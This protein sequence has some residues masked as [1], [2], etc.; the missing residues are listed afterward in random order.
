MKTNTLFGFVLAL[1]LLISS[2]PLVAAGNVSIYAYWVGANSQTL[3]VT[4]GDIPQ[5][6]ITGDSL[7]PAMNI[8]VE[9]LKNGQYVNTILKIDNLTQDSYTKQISLNTA[10]LLGV[11][12]VKVTITSYNAQDTEVLTLTVNPKVQTPPPPQPQN[13][14]PILNP[15]GNKFVEAG[16]TLEFT[17]TASD[18]DNDPLLFSAAP[19]PAGTTFN[20]V[21]GKYKYLP[22]ITGEHIIKFVVSDGKAED[23]ESIKITVT[24]AEEKPAPVP[25]PPVPPQN[26]PPVM[27]PIPTLHVNEGDT[28]SYKVSGTDAEHNQLTFY[29][30]TVIDG[31]PIDNN[32]FPV[33]VPTGAKF[34]AHT[35]VFTFSPKFDF[36]K[37]PKK[38]ETIQLRFKAY[39]GKA[40]STWKFVN[41]IV[42]DV[43]RKPV[44]VSSTD[45]IIVYAGETVSL[46]LFATDADT[47]DVLSYTMKNAPAAATLINTNFSWKTN[48]HD[49]GSYTMTFMVSDGLASDKYDTQLIVK[50]KPAVPKSQCSDGKDNDGDH[51]IDMNDP[52]CS[53]P[54]DNDEINQAPPPQ[55]NTPPVI[56]SIHTISGKEGQLIQF[57]FV[58]FD[59]DGDKLTVTPYS[60]DS[61]LG[62][63]APIKGEG[64]HVINN[65]DGTFTVQLK[66][67]Y[68]FVKHPQTNRTFTLLL[69][70]NDGKT[71]TSRLVTVIVADVNQ[72]PQFQP[73]SDRT[74]YVGDNLTFT[75]TADDA[76]SEDTLNYAVQNLPVGAKFNKSGFKWQP[77][78]SQVGTH[79]V[80]FT[81]SDGFV[82]VSE[83]VLITVLAKNDG[84]NNP[85]PTPP[86]AKTQCSDGLDN[87]GDGLIDMKDPG[88]SSALDNDEKNTASVP[89]PVVPPAK[90]ESVDFNIISVKIAPEVVILSQENSTEVLITVRNESSVKAEDLRAVVMIPDV[91]L[92]QSTRR[93]VLNAEKDKTVGVVLDIPYETPAGTYLVQIMLENE[94]FH[95]TMYRQLTIIK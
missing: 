49:L 70:L 90:V 87:D 27:N 95:N 40:F 52:G 74:V 57:S 4:Q 82:T 5:I 14:A 80:T 93:F 66:P 15:I 33:V 63:L 26:T 30:H 38:Q 35:G 8:S 58:V 36:V 83:P 43:N 60:A 7:A 28:I 39:D 78:A 42:N 37:H 92:I 48:F 64:V 22:K 9:L 56:G 29:V 73:M 86:P 41:I 75:V 79:T 46:E 10:S 69:E 6:M 62:D 54:Q 19:L 88:C 34:D 16:K 20:T 23:S 25:P 3:T 71:K 51:L 81:V 21:S 45:Q 31:A 12:T 76:D 17:V 2:A 67:L 47:E 24:A 18:V 61:I 50:E 89:P 91:G 1:M 77:M 59:K 55:K 85:P 11:Y 65:H 68:S 72:L 94:E 13:H 32:P 53:S 44:F 84:G